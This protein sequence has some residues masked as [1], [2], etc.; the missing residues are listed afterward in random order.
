MTDSQRPT[1]PLLDTA[2]DQAVREMMLVEGASDARA[3]VLARIEDRPAALLTGPRLVAAAAL[4]AVLVLAFTLTRGPAPVPTAGDVAGTTPLP[5]APSAPD[6]VLPHVPPLPEQTPDRGRTGARP[7][8]RARA[9]DAGVP[10]A[11]FTST[12]AIAPLRQIDPIVVAPLQPAP[13]EPDGIVIPPLA[14]IAELEIE[15]LFPS[16][17]RS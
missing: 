17:G 10:D 16:D 3:R 1:D 15:P 5:T 14:P 13:V 2:I 8:G 9:A 4:A 6:R 7:E 12:I 11:A